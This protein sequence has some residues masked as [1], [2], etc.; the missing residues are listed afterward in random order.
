MSAI[1][2]VVADDEPFSRERVAQLLALE[3]DIELVARC[4]D[5]VEALEAIRRSQPTVAFLDVRMPGLDGFE[6]LEELGRARP[7][8]VVFVT[9]F[10]QHAVEAFDVAALDYVVKPV[11]RD[12]FRETI[13]RLRE[14]IA[15][16]DVDESSRMR[17]TLAAV[18]APPEEHERLVVRSGRGR[19]VLEPASIDWIAAAGN[20]LWLHVGAST[21]L[22]R[23]TLSSF[24]ARPG[25]EGFV[26]IHRSTLVNLRSVA[27]IEPRG[28][29][30]ANVILRDGTEL[31]ASRTFARELR[32]R[33]R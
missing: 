4:A 13:A 14:R 5:G 20:Y 27:R 2:A 12:R 32:A 24:C 3:G 28:S 6:L 29:G 9:A 16:G 21:H 10:D 1:R 31:A 11:D 23:G 33:L 25:G 7:P 17:G 26:R 18:V 19:T 15:R 8:F 30:D 22:I